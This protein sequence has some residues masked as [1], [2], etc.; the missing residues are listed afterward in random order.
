MSPFVVTP[1][2]LCTITSIGCAQVIPWSLNNPFCSSPTD[3]YTSGENQWNF[4][5]INTCNLVPETTPVTY[6]MNIWVNMLDNSL[7]SSTY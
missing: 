5:L 3:G 2:S 7:K 4:G 1:S 6:T